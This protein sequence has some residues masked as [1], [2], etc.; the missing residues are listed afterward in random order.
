MQKTH[1]NNNN[2][3]NNNQQHTHTHTKKTPTITPKLQISS[4]WMVSFNQMFQLFSSVDCWKKN[5]EKQNKKI[6]LKFRCTLILVP[7]SF[8]SFWMCVINYLDRPENQTMPT[9]HFNYSNGNSRNSPT[10]RSKGHDCRT[11]TLSA[12]SL[13]AFLGMSTNTSQGGSFSTIVKPGSWHGNHQERTS[14]PVL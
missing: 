12:S 13:R 11:G 3:N 6:T 5:K 9:C 8:D 10:V 7:V 2:K 4:R 1:T 14:H